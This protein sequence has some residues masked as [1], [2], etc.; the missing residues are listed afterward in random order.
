MIV[1]EMFTIP[2]ATNPRIWA[3]SKKLQGVQID[4]N[5]NL[6]LAQASLGR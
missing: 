1:D 3:S 6:Y 4:L 2:I 5:G